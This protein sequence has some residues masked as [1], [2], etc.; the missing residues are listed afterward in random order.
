MVSPKRENMMLKATLM[1]GL[2]APVGGHLVLKPG[3]EQHQQAVARRDV[4]LPGVLVGDFRGGRRDDVR[5]WPGIVE[6][7]RVRAFLSL[8][9]VDAAQ[10]VVR[11]GMRAGGRLRGG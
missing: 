1:R 4:D 6:A 10:I 11:M 8:H 3:R 7:D 2:A 9:V 5:L